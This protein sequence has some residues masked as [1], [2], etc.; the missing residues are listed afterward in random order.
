[1]ETELTNTT[2]ISELIIDTINNLLNNLFSSIDNSV[3]ETLDKLTFI[4]QNIFQDS[5]IEKF[6]RKRFK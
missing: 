6:F 5:F 1:M 3:Y 2:N 4:D